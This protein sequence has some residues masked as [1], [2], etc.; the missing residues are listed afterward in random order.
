MLIGL[1]V[2]HW[3]GRMNWAKA[4]TN[5]A[6]F[7]FYKMSDFGS[8]SKK[9]FSDG[10]FLNNWHGTRDQNLVNGAYHWLQPSIDPKV[11]A[12]FYLSLFI[13]NPTNFAIL[14]FEDPKVTNWNDMLWRGQVWLEIVK[15]AL[16][17][18][19]ILLYTSKGYIS[20]FD[21][22][23]IGFL[24][25]FYLWL[26]QYTAWPIAYFPS[27]W[28]NWTFWQYTAKGDAIAFGASEA[29]SI[30]V[31]RFDGTLDD[32]RYLAGE[33]TIPVPPPPVEPPT[34]PT[35][36]SIQFEVLSDTLNLRSGP[37]TNFSI[38]GRLSKGAVVEVQDFGG[39]SCWIKSSAGWCAVDY[40]S[41]R[42]MR[43]LK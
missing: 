17:D 37:G 1:D 19:P 26:A 40:Q 38:V 10:Q 21:Q 15:D 23:K 24:G 16:P 5:G 18:I 20:S 25:K 9:P 22:S 13:K 35:V 39:S 12:D 41:T 27:I 4:V 34:P 36:G 8:T 2:S 30:D 6:K 11:Q 31:N 43:W 7:G 14:D 28:K 29:K 33:S 32:L 42:Y 3:Q